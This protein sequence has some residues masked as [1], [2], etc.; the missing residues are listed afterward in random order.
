MGI[1]F[2][3]SVLLHYCISLIFIVK[4][5]HRLCGGRQFAEP[6]KFLCFCVCLLFNFRL[7]TVIDLS[8]GV[9]SAQHFLHRPIHEPSSLTQITSSSAD[10]RTKLRP[11]ISF[12]HQPIHKPSSMT[13]ILSSPTNP[14][15]KL[16]K[17]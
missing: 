7:F 16:P 4:F 2:L 8:P 6:R 13:Q 5:F 9:L 17:H 14:R 1:G 15:T 3:E 11:P 12:L 10:P